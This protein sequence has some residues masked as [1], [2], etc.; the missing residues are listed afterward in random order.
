MPA[1]RGRGRIHGGRHPKTLNVPSGS[2]VTQRWL[3]LGPVPWSAGKSC[4][5]HIF[6]QSKTHSPSAGEHINSTGSEPIPWITEQ[7]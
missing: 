5:L 4:E 3:L 6:P 7:G 2:F 1:V